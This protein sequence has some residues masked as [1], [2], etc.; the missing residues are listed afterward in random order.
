MACIVDY[1]HRPAILFCT[2]CKGVAPFPLPMTVDQMVL[3][4]KQFEKQ[5]AECKKP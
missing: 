3:I 2:L 5:H 4:I 1:Q